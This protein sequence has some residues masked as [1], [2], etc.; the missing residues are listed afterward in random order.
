MGMF[1]SRGGLGD[2]TPVKAESVSA[3]ALCEADKVLADPN[4]D[5]IY[6]DL[7][8]NVEKEKTQRKET[9]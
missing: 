9:S 6:V 8:R 4:S 5:A 2:F 3:E 1:G 7:R